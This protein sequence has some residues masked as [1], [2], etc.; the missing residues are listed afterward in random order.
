VCR[1]VHMTLALG[2]FAKG[3]SGG[4]LLCTTEMYV[5]W[6]KCIHDLNLLCTTER[7]V[8]ALGCCA[9]SGWEGK[10]STS[11]GH[12]VL[13]RSKRAVTPAGV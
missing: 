7:V 10:A 8:V 5:Q 13:R 3:L 4:I 1:C 9:Y 2:A 12:A 6:M 11:F